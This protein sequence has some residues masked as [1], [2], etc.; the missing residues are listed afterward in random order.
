M[1]TAVNKNYVC[2]EEDA[3][4]QIVK[5]LPQLGILPN[6]PYSCFTSHYVCPHP[7]VRRLER[8][9]GG[10]PQEL[11]DDWK[12]KL[13][14]G[15]MEVIVE[16]N[17]H[18]LVKSKQSGA[19]VFKLS[20]EMDGSNSDSAKEAVANKLIKEGIRLGLIE[21]TEI[22]H[23]P[24]SVQTLM[25]SASKTYRMVLNEFKQKVD[26][27]NM[28]VTINYSGHHEMEQ[29][30]YETELSLI[31]IRRSDNEKVLQI[32]SDKQKQR[33]KNESKEAAA[34]QV[35]EECEKK[36]IIKLLPQ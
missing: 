4:V 8:M 12:Q 23:P 5:S 31:I 18:V 24:I 7:Q 10:T 13:E 17:K 3:C 6:S 19:V 11:L 15:N 16:D 22:E 36:E 32:S 35:I 30:C 33:G 1:K 28:M 21:V 20:S 29:S 14:A 2:A 26:N 27:S 9:L 34:Q 25:K